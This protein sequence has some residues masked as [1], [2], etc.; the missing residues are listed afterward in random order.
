MVDIAVRSPGSHFLKL[1]LGPVSA[2]RIVSNFAIHS[3]SLG[4]ELLEIHTECHIV[5]HKV[6]SSMTLIRGKQQVFPKLMNFT[7]FDFFLFQTISRLAKHCKSINK[8]INRQK[9]IDAL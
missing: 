4:L 8:H 7:L 1:V 9:K 6:S 2:S 3:V 5:A